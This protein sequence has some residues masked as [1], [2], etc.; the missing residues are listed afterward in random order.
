MSSQFAKKNAPISFDEALMT[1]VK[2]YDWPGNVRE[3]SNMVHRLSVLY[4]GQTLT[5]QSL[6]TSMLP[7]GMIEILETEHDQAFKAVPG[8]TGPNDTIQFEEENEIESILI[9]GPSLTSKT[10]STRL[11]SSSIILGST[12]AAKRPPAL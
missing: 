12:T 9:N 8:E 6:D 1:V 5:P 4:P 11:L 10:K 3:L 7:Q 2:R